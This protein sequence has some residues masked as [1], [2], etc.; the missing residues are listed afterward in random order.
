[1][2]KICITF[3][4]CDIC[5]CDVMAFSAGQIES[6]VASF[7]G[8]NTDYVIHTCSNEYTLRTLHALILKF[9]RAWFLNLFYVCTFDISVLPWCHLD[10]LSF[11]EGQSIIKRNPFVDD[12][13]DPYFCL[14]L[15]IITDWA[16]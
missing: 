2:K 4:V 7:R 9:D 16:N 11:L 5:Q 15:P 12:H 14:L 13:D 10:L 6:I 3:F 8:M 1:M